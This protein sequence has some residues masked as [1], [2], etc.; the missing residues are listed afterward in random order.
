MSSAF[1]GFT[2]VLDSISLSVLPNLGSF[3]PLFQPCP[4]SRFLGLNDMN[5]RSFVSFCYRSTSLLQFFSSSFSFCYSGCVILLLFSSSLILS[6]DNC[7]LLLS[8]Y[9]ECFYFSYDLFISK[10]SIWLFSYFFAEI[11]YFFV[12]SM[13]VNCSLKCF[14][15]GCFELF[16]R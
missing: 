6:S 1:L 2:Q 16:V 10:I 9:T 12:S 14:Y 7:F 5:V 4:L 13:F 8:T 15:H 11:F 3:Q